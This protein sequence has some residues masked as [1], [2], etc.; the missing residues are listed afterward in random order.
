[1]GRIAGSADR[2]I[3]PSDNPP[4]RPDTM[5]IIQGGTLPDLRTECLDRILELGRNGHC[6]WRLFS[7]EPKDKNVPDHRRFSR[8]DS[9]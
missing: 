1:M 2:S 5:P 7:R 6:D 9:R 3:R 4:I 8:H